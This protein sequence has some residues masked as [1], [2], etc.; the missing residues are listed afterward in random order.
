MMTS[1][2]SSPRTFVDW[3]VKNLLTPGCSAIDAT[4]GNGQDTLKLCRLCL[5]EE[6][7]E[8]IFA[9]DLQKEALQRTHQLLQGQLTTGQLRRVHLIEA[10]HEQFPS[11]AKQ[12]PISLIIYNL[13]YLP[14]SDR[15]LT[16][17]VATTLTS[18]QEAI[19]L[20]RTGGSIL[21]SCYPGHEEGLREEEAL[22]RFTG[23]LSPRSWLVTH[24]R[25]PNRE[26]CPSVLLLTKNQ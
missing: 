15:S 19:K 24:Q 10:S 8:A 26:A 25:W 21:I 3:I 17:Q 7:N 22:L 5:T 13:G 6:G 9:I 11:A 16:T 2:L 4:C 23:S 14:G 12:L 18:L 1:H 20:V